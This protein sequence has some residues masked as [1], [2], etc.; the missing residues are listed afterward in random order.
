MLYPLSYGGR[1]REDTRQQPGAGSSARSGSPPSRDRFDLGELVLRVETE[2]LDPSLPGADGPRAG[3]A[4]ARPA[5]PHSDL[6]LRSHGDEHLITC[7]R[8]HLAVGF[9]AALR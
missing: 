7:R 5:P 6:A 9:E 4:M 1:T 3:G 8:E 2:R